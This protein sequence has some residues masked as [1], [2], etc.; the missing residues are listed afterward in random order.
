MLGMVLL[1]AAVFGEFSSAMTQLPV[2]GSSALVKMDSMDAGSGLSLS[3]SKD[4][5]MIK[6][7][8]IYN[9]MMIAETG[10]ATRG[11]EGYMDAWLVRNG[12]AVPNSNN[13]IGISRF[14]QINLFT[15]RLMIALKAGDMLSAGYSASG[16]G[17]GFIYLHLDNEPAIPSF[18]FSIYKVD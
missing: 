16:P 17:L 11:A 2:S 10:A 7:D 4:G 8:G 14:T 5:V 9:V 15:T 1:G 13:R 18:R 6:E 12:K 3:P